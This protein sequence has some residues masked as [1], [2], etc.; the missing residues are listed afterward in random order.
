MTQ[1]VPNRIVIYPKDVQNITGKKERTAR[2]LISDIRK[3][4]GKSKH[5]FV[6]IDDFCSYTGLKKEQIYSFMLY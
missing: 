4:L 2:K 3:S 5:E 1:L 6:T